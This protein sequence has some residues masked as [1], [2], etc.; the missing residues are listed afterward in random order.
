MMRQILPFRLAGTDVQGT[1]NPDQTK[2]DAARMGAASADCV[3]GRGAGP[4]PNWPS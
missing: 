3:L 1:W 4:C 2:T